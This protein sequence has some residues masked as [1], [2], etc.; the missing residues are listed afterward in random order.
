MEFLG[1]GD[2]HPLVPDLAELTCRDQFHVYNSALCLGTLVLR[3]PG[4]AMATFVLEQI[5]AAVSLFTSLTHHGGSTPRYRRNLQ[6]LQK[7]RARASS[8]IAMAASTAHTHRPDLRRDA[9]AGQRTGS[10]DRE[11]EAEDFELLG[12][13]T[14]LIERAGRG[15]PTIST[16]RVDAGPTGPRAAADDP[17]GAPTQRDGVDHIP[18][19]SRLAETTMP[20]ASFLI[21]PAH[22]E[23]TDDIVRSQPGPRTT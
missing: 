20:S 12:W 23:P 14:R 21:S 19:R 1:T 2:T 9:G 8:K 13:R 17:F 3:D 16:I 10:D 7:L 5:D 11:E 22:P 18:G 15:R 4:N 6:W